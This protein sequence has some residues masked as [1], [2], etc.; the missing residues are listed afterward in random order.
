MGNSM[1]YHVYTFAA[2]TMSVTAFLLL[3]T[4]LV[5]GSSQGILAADCGLDIPCPTKCGECH[6]EVFE[7]EE[8]VE[9]QNEENLHGGSCEVEDEE[10]CDFCGCAF[11]TGRAGDPDACH[12]FPS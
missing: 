8:V 5:V 1:K 9:C 10:E 4:A 11:E 6:P 2:R 3:N 7:E 12:C